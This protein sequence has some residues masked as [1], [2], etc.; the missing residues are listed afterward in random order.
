MAFAHI[1]SE[2]GVDMVID[3]EPT[4][5]EFFSDNIKEIAYHEMSHASDYSQVG[6]TWY[7]NFVTA[8]LTE[9]QNNPSGSYDPYGTGKTSNSPIIALGEAWGYHMGHFLADQQYG[10]NAYCESEQTDANGNGIHYCPNGNTNSPNHPDIDV[11][12]Y[13][14]PTLSTDPF[15][16]IPK[17]LMEDMMDNG[18][19]AAVTGVND[20]VS[21]YTIKQLFTA[22]QS[23]VTTMAQ[24]KARIVQQ[25]PSNTTNQ[26]LTSLFSSYGY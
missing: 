3:Y 23:D 17:G 5:G 24:Y 20:Q 8:E 13:F 1:A 4:N 26:Y 9:I 14:T 18:E 2:I 21:G 11:L 15:K 25:N 6:K 16:W 19:P 10:I 7:Q 12:E 22:L